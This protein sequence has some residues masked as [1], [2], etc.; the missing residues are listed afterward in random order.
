MF[1]RRFYRTSDVAAIPALG[2][3]HNM[4]DV[5]IGQRLECR[6]CHHTW[7]TR[8]QR[9]PVQCPKCKSTSWDKDQIMVRTSAGEISLAELWE[10]QKK[11]DF[12]KL[13][14]FG[15]WA[16]RE[17]SDEELLRELGGGFGP[18]DSQDD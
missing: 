16:D 2:Y 3:Y 8:I 11:T 6:K 1:T 13:P 4:A 12:T 9:K 17:E 7:N 14:S 18:L 15:M 10:L 5:E